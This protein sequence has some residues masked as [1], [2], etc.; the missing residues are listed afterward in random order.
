[1]RRGEID[2]ESRVELEVV[3]ASFSRGA[4]PNR[5]VW[6]DADIGIRR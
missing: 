2:G 4:S 6:R 1:M 5:Q 3:S